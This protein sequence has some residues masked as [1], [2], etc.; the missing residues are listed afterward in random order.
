MADGFNTDDMLDVFLYENTQLLENLQEIVLEK[1]DEDSFDE[2]SVNEIFRIMHTIKGSSGI[3]MYDNI[4]KISHKLEDVFY[5]IRESKPDNVP[6]GELVDHIFSVLDFIT[7][8]MDKIQDGESPDGDPSEIIAEV[9]AFLNK[10][11]NIDSSEGKKAPPE[12]VYEEPKQF[13]IAPMATNEKKYYRVFIKYQQDT[14]MSNL[15]AYTAVFSLKEV[16]E[17]LLYQ[18]DDIVSNEDSGNYILEHGFK[19]LIQ[20]QVDKDELLKLIDHSSGVES[21]DIDEISE[22]EFMFGFEPQTPPVNKAIPEPAKEDTKGETEEKK[23]GPAPGDYVIRD[24]AP[25][26]PK[27]MGRSKANAHKQ[28]L[29][30]VSIDKMDMLMD[31]IGELVIAQAVVLQNPDL[32]VP[33]LDL[34][35]FKK[36]A[37]QL[38]KISSE[39][40]EV[41]MSMR[42]IPLKNTF[43]KMNRI[44]F[45][46]SKKLGKEIDLEIIGED[47]EVDKNIIEHISDPLMHLI[48][49]SV[50]HGI[51]MPEERV[52]AG[53]E[54]KGKITLLAKNE[55]GKVWI[56]VSD[57]GK[58]L[59]REKILKK[60]KENGLLGNK[61]PAQLSDKEVYQFITYAGFSTKEKVTE[62]SGRGVG[63]DVV[64]K[65]IQSVGGSLEIDSVEGQGS[66]M[67][68]KIP[69]TLAIID[70]IVMSVGNSKFVIETGAVKE[71]VNANSGM[72]VQEPDGEEYIMIRGECFPV[73]RLKEVFEL[74]EGVDNIDDGI[75]V[76]LEHEGRV[77]C[78][79]VDCL[80]GEQEI[81]VKPIP[82]YIKK[83][84]GLSGC[85]QL[86]D[87][88]IAL[89]LDA[90]GLITKEPKGE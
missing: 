50:D 42:M 87:G 19:M 13:Y 60:A 79:F 48:R 11:K 86:G 25:G 35:N 26:K 36:A 82:S 89:I 10:I 22:Q 2:A 71:F 51:E 72:M 8:E 69:L 80:V 49:N 24:K 1:K 45:D 84:Q 23:K 14:Q 7:G 18:P 32:Q 85:T 17:D 66:T 55:G 70:G 12:N 67:T 78:L 30:S 27:Q 62:Y 81:V 68:L 28:S 5:Y 44:V 4:T 21:L 38:S 34:T 40:Q 29:I 43:Q 9:D 63:M 64:V 59:N 46:V 57:N 74:S 20:T 53:K 73:I 47:T 56:S 88:S 16:A 77:V 83:I 31:L 33:D 15:R 3:M 75:V 39:L 41:I 58:G 52:A 37:N 90:G 54:E 61:N 76:V 6:H 65:N